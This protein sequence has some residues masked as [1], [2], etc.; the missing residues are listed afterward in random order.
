MEMKI[1]SHRYDTNRPKFSHEHKINIKRVS[2]WVSFEAQFI[3][4]LSNTEAELKKSVAYKKESVYK[5]RFKYWGQTV[6]A[7]IVNGL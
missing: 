1:R 2:V 6:T 7:I 3:K 4:T 5:E